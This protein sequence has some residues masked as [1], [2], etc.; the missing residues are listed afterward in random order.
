MRRSTTLARVLLCASAC[1][2]IGCGSSGPAP[3]TD[4]VPVTG[5]LIFE[6]KPLPDAKI[7]FIP[8]DKEMT[9]RPA[10]TVDAEGNFEVFCDDQPGAP[11]ANYRVI[12]MAFKPSEDD[13]Q[14][15]PS[16]IPE[17]YNS[18]KTSGI[19][20]NVKEDGDNVFNFKIP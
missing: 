10:A 17:R 11:P 12:V 6:G 2:L 4:L 16:L 8:T 20:A 13:E 1:A 19:S 7:V 14:K 3:R 15:P 9:D 5:T 18:D